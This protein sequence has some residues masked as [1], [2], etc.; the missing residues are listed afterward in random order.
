MNN[1]RS[2]FGVL[3]GKAENN[4]VKRQEC[5]IEK[6]MWLPFDKAFESLTYDTDR[7]VLEKAKEY[8][9]KNEKI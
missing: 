4:D 3:K 5:E 2:E 7:D 6:V 9:V 1:L 8:L